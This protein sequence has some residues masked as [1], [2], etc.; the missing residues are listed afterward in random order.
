MTLK[1]SNPGCLEL[2]LTGEL[3]VRQCFSEFLDA[4]TIIQLLVLNRAIWKNL[5]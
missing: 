5:S 4:L 3:S 2:L 1:P